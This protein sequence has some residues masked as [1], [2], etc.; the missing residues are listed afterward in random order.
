MTDVPAELQAWAKYQLGEALADGPDR[1]YKEAMKHHLQAIA[2]AAPLADERRFEVRRL[3]KQ[4]LVDAHLAVARDI[5]LGDFQRKEEVAPKWINRAEALIGN[6]VSQEQGDPALPLRALRMTLAVS[7]ELNAAIDPEQPAERAIN[8][9]RQLIAAD[10]DEL[11]Q[12]RLQWELGQTLFE[13]MRVARL[14]LKHE[15]A[16]AHANNAIVLFEQSAPKRQSTPAQKELIGRLYFLVGTIH[17]V[18]LQDHAEAVAWYEKAEPILRDA[19]PNA[20]H[21]EAGLHGERFVSMGVSHWET[22]HHDKALQLTE[23]GLTILQKGVKDGYVK[24]D[25]LAVPYGNLAAMYAQVGNA[26]QSKK[27]A[28]MASKLESPLHGRPQ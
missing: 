12:S 5:A 15:V 3:A 1:D 18:Q 10:Q 14:Q 23:H 6:V 26:E 22:G 13:A 20:P 11:N 8:L 2:I 19:L 7:A 28:A 27:F 17:A 21:A 4:V 24:A 25:A 9:A 16:L